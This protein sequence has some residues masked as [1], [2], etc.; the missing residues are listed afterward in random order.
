MTQEQINNNL[1]EIKKLLEIFN[2][3]LN[4]PVMLLKIN[5]HTYTLPELRTALGISEDTLK[6]YIEIGVLRNGRIIKLKARDFGT[7]SKKD[8]RVLWND[9]DS[10]F[11][12]LSTTNNISNSGKIGIEDLIG[13][14]QSKKKLKV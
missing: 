3:K 1:T 6:K 7:G 4:D 8:Y 11:K 14:S 12:D 5:Y 9:L 2:C 10:F 13:L